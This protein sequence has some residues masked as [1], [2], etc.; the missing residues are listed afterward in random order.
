ML[1]SPEEG[2]VAQG[3]AG[4]PFDVTEKAYTLSNT[5]AFPI[6]FAV[7]HAAP[8]LTASPAEGTIP[9]GGS[10]VVT[11]AL[12]E[13]AGA[14]V[15]AYWQ[16]TVQIANLT[17]HEGD[18]TRP[19]S[20]TVGTPEPQLDWP[21]DD[22]PGWTTE[23]GWAFGTPAGLGG[24]E[25]GAP[26]PTSGHTGTS[27]YGYALQG[28]YENALGETSLTSTAIDCSHM[29]KVSLRFWRW[30]NVQDGQHD[31]AS[32]RVS[33]DGASWT[34]V[35]E[36][37]DA[38]ADSAWQS[39][40]IDIAAIADGQPTVYL[41]WT[42]GATDGTVSASGWN[43]DDVALWGLG[44]SCNDHDGDGALPLDCGGDDCDDLDP[45]AHVGALET[46]D[47]GRDNDCD[48]AVDG[49]DSDCLGGPS[50]SGG[51][52]SLLGDRGLHGMV[53]G[54]RVPGDPAPGRGA[55][56]LLALLGAALGLRRRRRGA[57]A[58][59]SSRWHR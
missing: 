56:G 19:V 17:D 18:T 3:P 36:N 5:R 41:R 59:S 4:G 29:S 22:D 50:S 2:L 57:R 54:C 23:G 45:T 40:E 53:C 37:T 8:W 43:I 46:C 51:P 11:V 58:S 33:N 25:L 14:L 44:R 52:G 49:A 27:V 24:S 55:I 31:H 28:D 16:D 30:L 9:A 26:D 10:A 47:D 39:V 13:A 12:A 35:W 42:M 6:D 34:T 32:V 38:V 20:L 1:V 7:E 15:E 21:L 48:G